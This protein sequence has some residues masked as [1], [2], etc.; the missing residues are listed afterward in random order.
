M[1][2]QCPEH[3]DIPSFS[4]HWL[5]RGKLTQGILS[6]KFSLYQTGQ[7][8]QQLVT[9]ISVPFASCG[10]MWF[11]SIR[12]TDVSTFM[13]HAQK[14][15][16][17]PLEDPC[18]MLV[19]LH[20]CVCL[21][22]QGQCLMRCL[23]ACHRF[24]PQDLMWLRGPRATLVWRAGGPQFPAQNSKYCAALLLSACFRQ[25]VQDWDSPKHSLKNTTDQR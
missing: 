3:T 11:I 17:G 25:H 9:S 19:V 7:S 12:F 10:A 24:A 15:K 14:I 5:H 21:W 4:L 13:A 22:D 18:R 16:Q 6:L 2:V 20:C 23:C 1:P 8:K